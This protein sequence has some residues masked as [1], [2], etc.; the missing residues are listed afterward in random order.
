[1]VTQAQLTLSVKESAQEKENSAEI[2]LRSVQAGGLEKNKAMKMRHRLRLPL[3]CPVIFASDE[4]VGEGTVV[5][6]GV[7]GCAVESRV[8]PLTR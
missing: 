4:F 6:L 5:D 1:M 8:T 3:R 2:S 7:P